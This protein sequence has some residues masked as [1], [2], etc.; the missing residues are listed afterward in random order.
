MSASRSP[1]VRTAKPKRFPRRENNDSDS[2]VREL[3][4]RREPLGRRT[5][6]SAS[7]SGGA[8]L[9]AT[10]TPSTTLMRSWNRASALSNGMTHVAAPR[11]SPASRQRQRRRKNR[12]RDR[13]GAQARIEMI[14]PLRGHDD[15]TPLALAISTSPP[16]VRST[17]YAHQ[18]R[19]SASHQTAGAGRAAREGVPH[20]TALPGLWQGAPRAPPTQL[21]LTQGKAILEQTRAN[22]SPPQDAKARCTRNKEPRFP[23]SSIEDKSDAKAGD[24]RH[25]QMSS[26]RP[27]I[28]RNKGSQGQE[29]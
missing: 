29:D 9:K 1:R 4:R 21:F 8:R 25:G 23:P 16:L 12:N 28:R 24:K 3:E 14:R 27:K 20:T 13:L 26:P 5:V 17:K 19:T 6:G 15:D 2:D 22:V 18:L 10:V 11:A 7:G